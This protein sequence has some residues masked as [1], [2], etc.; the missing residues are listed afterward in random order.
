V[1]TVFKMGTFDL[2]VRR[3][4]FLRLSGEPPEEQERIA[5]WWARK[6]PD[7]D[8]RRIVA[9]AQHKGATDH[10]KHEIC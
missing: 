9:E 3:V 1:K 8:W 10:R 6:F 2:A 7:L 4:R 5:K